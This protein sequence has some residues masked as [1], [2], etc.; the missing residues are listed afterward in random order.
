[1]PRTSSG[2]IDRK[3]LVNWCYLTS[4]VMMRTYVPD[5]KTD[6][7]LNDEPPSKLPFHGA[8]FDSPPPAD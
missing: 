2:K 3:R 4:D 7:D 1:M 6:P 5:L 8:D